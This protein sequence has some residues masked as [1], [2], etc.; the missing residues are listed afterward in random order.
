MFYY[1][2]TTILMLATVSL[3]LIIK[4][5]QLGIDFWDMVKSS[6]NQLI[7]EIILKIMKFE[8]KH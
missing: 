4:H 6:Q 5:H 7:R 1:I 3:P 2:P 8:S